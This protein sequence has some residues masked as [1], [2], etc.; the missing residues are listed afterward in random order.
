MRVWLPWGLEKPQGQPAAE[1]KADNFRRI[2]VAFDGKSSRTPRLEDTKPQRAGVFLGEKLAAVKAEGQQAQAGAE[3]EQAA[4]LGCGSKEDL[5]IV[6]PVL[7]DDRA[8]VSIPYVHQHI[9]RAIYRGGWEV[10][11]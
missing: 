6:V 7:V 1:E 2:Q 3:Q 10:L 4:W 11:R 5:W 9:A 8:G